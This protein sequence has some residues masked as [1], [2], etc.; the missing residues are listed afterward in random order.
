MINIENNFGGGRIQ[1]ALTLRSFYF[2]SKGVINMSKKENLQRE[3]QNLDRKIK[4]L[5]TQ[6][7]LLKNKLNNKVLTEQQQG[8]RVSKLD[9]FRI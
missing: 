9:A 8:Q 3:I 1:G 6:R 7:A 2:L 4:V 5:E